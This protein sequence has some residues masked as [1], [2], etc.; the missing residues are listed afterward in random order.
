MVSPFFRDPQALSS[1]LTAPGTL[2]PPAFRSQSRI[3]TLDLAPNYYLE[4]IQSCIWCIPN[5]G[6]NVQ[7][8]T[9]L[10][11]YVHALII[12]EYKSVVALCVLYYLIPDVR[13]SPD[14]TR[15][16]TIVEVS[17]NFISE[18]H[19]LCACSTI[20]FTEDLRLLELVSCFFIVHVIIEN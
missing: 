9:I 17:I 16:I 15:I 10:H 12:S 3:E 8:S 20:T 6:K 14:H 4:C 19:C 5:K 1:T 13:T 7:V 11:Y 2:Q 18:M